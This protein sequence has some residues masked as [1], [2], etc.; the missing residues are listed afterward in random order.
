MVQIIDPA[1]ETFPYKGRLNIR[2]PGGTRRFLLGRA[3]TAREAY[4]ARLADHNAKIAN[5]ASRLGWTLIRHRTD[6][7]ATT[8]LNALYQALSGDQ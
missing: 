7:P 8:A 4:Q 2:A 6:E 1:E 3:E 5:T